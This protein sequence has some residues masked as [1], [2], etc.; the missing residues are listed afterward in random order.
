M[1]VTSVAAN[2]RDHLNVYHVAF[3]KLT[4][5]KGGEQTV[6]PATLLLP[7]GHGVPPFRPQGLVFVAVCSVPF[8][9]PREQWTL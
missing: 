1:V 5:G 2:K 4:F 9:W 7:Q 6:N 8:L 3:C